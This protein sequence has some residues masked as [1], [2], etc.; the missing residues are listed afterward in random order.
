MGFQKSHFLIGFV[1]LLFCV[2]CVKVKPSGAI[3]VV[4]REIVC[5]GNRVT[6]RC[7]DIFFTD[8]VKFEPTGKVIEV[9]SDYTERTDCYDYDTPSNNTTYKLYG[10]DMDNNWVLLD[11]QDV[12]VVQDGQ[13][14]KYEL[15]IIGE[16]IFGDDILTCKYSLKPN[17][18]DYDDDV[19]ITYVK[20][21]ASE[22][23]WNCEMAIQHV[24]AI[25]GGLPRSE[26]SYRYCGDPINGRW[27]FRNVDYECRDVAREKFF[28]TGIITCPTLGLEIGLT[29]DPVVFDGDSCKIK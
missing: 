23:E 8:K 25:I 26:G 2:G 4:P 29:C 24:K 7:A 1:L 21:D 14:N 3:H 27:R 13:E 5:S 19:L 28:S 17:H 10:L 20:N 12:I 6:L 16:N 22:L 18:L 15:E 9:T 11:E